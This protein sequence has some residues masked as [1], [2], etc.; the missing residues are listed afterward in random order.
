MTIVCVFVLHAPSSSDVPV[1]LLNQPNIGRTNAS[2][3]LNR[4]RFSRNVYC[5]PG[6]TDNEDPV[7]REII[8]GS[9][10]EEAQLQHRR[11]KC[12]R[13][14]QG[15]SMMKAMYRGKGKCVD[16]SGFEF[17]LET[18]NIGIIVINMFTMAL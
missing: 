16:F 4:D 6:L 14:I 15:G 13:N 12:A 10:K 11:L 3:W 8:Q 18:K 17:F 1:L 7:T 2:N 9:W 5:P